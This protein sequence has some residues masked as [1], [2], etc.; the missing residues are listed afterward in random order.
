MLQLKKVNKFYNTK[1][2]KNHILKDISLNFKNHGL[3]FILGKS[4]S[5][6]STLLNIIGGLDNADS[7]EII[8]LNKNINKFSNEEM[9]SYRNNYVGFIFQEFNLIEDYTVYQNIILALNLQD[10]KFDETEIDNLLEKLEI[11]DFKN[12]K[13]DELSGGER[14][15]VA[16]ARALVKR[17]KMILADEPTGNLDSKT[18][19][20]VM[21]LLKK[22]SQDTLVI[23]VTHD[24]EFAKNY[25]DNIIEIKDGQI[26]N[27]LNEE[28]KINEE[29]KKNKNK[30]PFKDALSL[31]NNSLKKK[32]IKL[33]FTMLLIAFSTFFINLM[34]IIKN[35]DVDE[36]HLNLLKENDIS[37]FE[38]RKFGYNKQG[39]KDS[40]Y[41]LNKKDILH[42]TNKI[43]SKYYLNYNINEAGSFT[44]LLKIDI[45]NL[46]SFLDLIN[47][48]EEPIY[49]E[50]SKE[51][52]ILEIESA[53]EFIK[54][55][56]LI[57]RFV[58]END[59]I[60]ISNYIAD[61]IIKYGIYEYNSNNIFYPKSYEE[62]VTSSKMF[63]FGSYNSIKIVGIINYDLN[64]YESLKTEY[65]AEYSVT[66]TLSNEI[67]DYLNK[68][69][70]G[71]GFIKNLKI[72]HKNTLDDNN[73]YIAKLNNINLKNINMIDSEL[74]YYDGQNWM[75]TSSLK[76]DEMLLNIRDIINNYDLYVDKLNE[77]INENSFE[78]KLELEKK[79]I[80][81]YIDLNYINKKVDLKIYEEN[82]TF[83][84]QN[85]EPNKSY[86]IKV[87]GITGLYYSN[88]E[89][90]LF[91]KEIL[92]EYINEYSQ[93]K[94]II[95]VEKDKNKIINIAKEFKIKDKYSLTNEFSTSLEVYSDNMKS[96]S[97]FA[98]IGIIVFTLFS[99]ILIMNFMF[100][101]ISSRKKDIGILKS[102][103]A[104]NKDII[105]I[106]IIE[107]LLLS[108]LSILFN[109]LITY[110]L[111]QLLNNTMMYIEY[112]SINPF[113]IN[114]KLISL[115]AIYII[116]SILISSIIPLLKISKMKPIDA[117]N[118]R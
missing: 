109:I 36:N 103:G 100:N 18:G 42:I 108:F 64:K 115:S 29:Y 66:K 19:K 90:N 26:L 81:N 1:N 71:K 57:G 110:L 63:N 59:E 94:S 92:E 14:Q 111:F 114:L 56:T 13:I 55:G 107:G 4:G 73:F 39:K 102:L 86:D 52:N 60:I 23:V 85:M 5:G 40:V 104:R 15:R 34:V 45:P 48:P 31:G 83:N 49:Y 80:L 78:D 72:G 12:R 91:S 118:K 53:D 84:F 117:I 77:Y 58:Q 54:S 99:F 17:P 61:Y 25:G 32:K 33:F 27:T 113:Y 11:K 68:I 22:I 28:Y 62:I 74:E 43:N 112:N 47:K 46:E 67:N 44:N 24:I 105:K 7:G 51:Y 75:K 69:Y 35:Y 76:P 89:D 116:I 101:S 96:I 41:N 50:E 3:V 70:V 93:V 20:E 88:Q 98:F 87:I 38:I 65:M 37:Q 21:D 95:I 2:Q 10:K 82:G 16:I 106:F 79:F 9:D 6:K 97:I 8:F 30:L